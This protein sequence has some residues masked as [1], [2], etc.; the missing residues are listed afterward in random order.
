VR[1]EVLENG[2]KVE[3]IKVDVRF[4]GREEERTGCVW[5]SQ[6]CLLISSTEN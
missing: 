6:A 4:D 2:R 1:I 3:D 5:C